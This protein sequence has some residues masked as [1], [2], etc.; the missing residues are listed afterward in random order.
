VFNTITVQFGPDTM[1]ASKVEMRSG[2]SIEAAVQH[3]NDMERE[4][5]QR[6]PNLKWVFIEPDVAD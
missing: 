5:K 4:L 3:I 6:V 1:L 2:M